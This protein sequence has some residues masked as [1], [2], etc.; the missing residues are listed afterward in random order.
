MES[1]IVGYPRVMLKSGIKFPGESFLDRKGSAEKPQKA[2]ANL[3]ARTWKQM[4]AGGIKYI[5]SNAFSYCDQV[6]DTTAMLGAVFP[7][8]WLEWGGGWT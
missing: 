3:R 1:R 5:P 2:T 4:A 7:Q 8:I 6:L